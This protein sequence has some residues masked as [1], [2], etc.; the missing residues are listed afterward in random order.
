MTARTDD[1]ALP[2]A[3]SA[4]IFLSLAGVACGMA[5]L[6]LGMRAVMEIGGACAE[7]VSPYAIARPCPR[8]APAALVGGFWAGIVCLGIYLWQTTSR[9]IP[10]LAL[11]AWPALFLSL[12][13]NFL[14]FAFRPPGGGGPVWGW[15]VNGVVFVAMGGAPLALAAG[16]Q[17]RRFT[18]FRGA[19][20]PARL[21]IRQPPPTAPEEPRGAEVVS[22]LERL[23]EL[24]ASGALGD[25]EYRLAK[26][27]VL[28]A[29]ARR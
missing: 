18:S 17:V 11:L 27:R 14:E 2:L 29:G 15:L 25:E 4:W 12:G 6:F 22:A 28:D 9:G 10:N 7:G 19:R 5:F 21:E 13:W 24:H 26:A 20:P 1:D 16:P 3:A 8:G 23:A